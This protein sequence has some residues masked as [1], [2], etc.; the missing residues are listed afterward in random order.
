MTCRR[1]FQPKVCAFVIDVFL[2][3]FSQ[4]KTLSQNLLY[5]KEIC[6]TNISVEQ[7]SVLKLVFL[8][9]NTPI[10]IMCSLL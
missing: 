6:D 8:E 1:R 10:K 5:V 4:K 2:A 7:V 9:S 3:L